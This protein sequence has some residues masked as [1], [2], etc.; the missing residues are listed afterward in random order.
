MRQILGDRSILP[1]SHIGRELMQDEKFQKLLKFCDGVPLVIVVVGSFIRDRGHEFL[2][3]HL[4]GSDR[5]SLS[6]EAAYKKIGEALQEEFLQKLTTA[7]GHVLLS[8]SDGNP[9]F[10]MRL[11]RS[12]QFLCEQLEK[13]PRMKELFLDIVAVHLGRKCKDVKL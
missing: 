2:D 13:C 10:D 8:L 5:H 6:F 12:L 11:S 7:A 9:I 3:E 1:N 4:S